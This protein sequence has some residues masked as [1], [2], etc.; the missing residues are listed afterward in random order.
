M[1]KLP[2]YVQIAA[3]VEL[4][5]IAIAENFD[6]LREIADIRQMKGTAEPY[7]RLKFGV[8]RYLL[9]YDA[10]NETVDVLS[11]LHRKDA[12]KR[13]NLPWLR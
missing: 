4:N 2:S 8:Y 10:Q 9:Y 5:K 13:Q 3:R 1:S 11:L 12:Y 6:S 7:Y